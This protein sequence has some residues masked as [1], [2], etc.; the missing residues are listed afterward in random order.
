MRK[1]KKTGSW[2]RLLLLALIVI[3]GFAVYVA[4]VGPPQEERPDGK[5][6]R[7]PQVKTAPRHHEGKTT[8]VLPLEPRRHIVSGSDRRQIALIID[9]LGQDPLVLRELLDLG[10]PLT[11]AILPNC[12]FSGEA[13]RR[14][15]EA[16]ME[17]LLHL[18]MEPHGYPAHNP[19]QGALL[20]TMDDTEL[21][22]QLALD[23][24]GVPYARGVNN[25][26][27]SLFM[28]DEKR[29]EV[30]FRELGRRHLF[31]VDSRTTANTKAAEAAAKTGIRFLSRSAF[32]DNGADSEETYQI[33]TRTID[34]GRQNRR[35]GRILIGHPYPSTVRALKRLLREMPDSDVDWVTI[36]NLH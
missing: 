15:N 35:H 31:F 27:G 23:L 6:L 10:I 32:I 16:G 29:L 22:Q 18:P 5:A 4:L 34:D 30:V 8:G 19:G 12:R 36:S 26:M 1:K 21:S 24:D 33:L 20:T 11:V 7:R 2:R 17:V 25:H 14:A 9:D 3:A 13:A 28:E